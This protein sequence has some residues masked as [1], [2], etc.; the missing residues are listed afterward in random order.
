MKYFAK[1]YK[2]LE[3]ILAQE[4]TDMGAQS[5][6]AD[7]RGVEFEGDQELLYEA[8]YSS[9]YALR[10][11]QFLFEFEA[12]NEEELYQGF[13]EQ[14]M[15]H[16]LFDISQ[17]FAIDAIIRDSFATHS[18]FIALKSKDAIADQFVAVKGKRPDVDTEDPTY[19]IHLHVHRS[20]CKVYLD[21]SGSSLHLRGYRKHLGLAPLSEV[22]AAALV[23]LSGW[24]QDTTL[25]DPMC[26]SG[27]IL[28]EA[29]MQALDW[30]AQFF[31]PSFGCQNWN[32]FDGA[33]WEN[34]RAKVNARRKD[35]LEKPLLGFDRDHVSVR[36][37]VQNLIAA[38]I[39]GDVKV[40]AQDFFRLEK[41]EGPC[42]IITNPPYDERVR[43]PDVKRFYSNLGTTLK[44][45]WPGTTAWI[46]AADSPA[47][48]EVGLRPSA[49]IHLMNGPI[50]CQFL[51][52][53]LYDGTKKNRD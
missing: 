45:K 33:L 29:A 35:V 40:D 30:P 1:T 26:G 23:K 16:E 32:D 51:R 50:P 41:P 11:L 20:S 17:T 42:M 43:L 49:K 39:Y 28:I 21:A 6:R 12:N 25:I 2:G 44:H 24:N 9:R 31:R 52:F 4:L 27:T 38:R 48:K 47:L 19:R 53:D 34:M 18:K 10:F 22:L 13:R 8:N 5:V 36:K 37:C 46:L 15:W 3:H 7:F 14:F